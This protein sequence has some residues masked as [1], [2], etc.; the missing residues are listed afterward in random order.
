MGH[1][2]SLPPGHYHYI[3]P[4]GG[5][6]ASKFGTWL[7]LATEVHL[8]TALFAA[9]AVM[10]WKFPEMFHEGAHHLNWKLGML[11]TI[12]LLSSSYFMVRGV[13]A[14]QHGDNKKTR[15]WLDLTQLCAV[16]F[17]V[18]KAFEYGSKFSHGI[19]PGTNQFYGLYFTM[20]GIHGVHVIVGMGLIYWLRC[21]T[22]SDRFSKNFY[23]PVETVGLYWHLVDA[24]WIFLYPIV[25]LLGGVS[26][27][28][29]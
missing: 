22:K 23:T 2:K 6:H 26:L 11:N 8:F 5:Y 21:L 20:T 12:V 16:I 28:I 10:R 9:F 1:G 25:Y 15:F 14:A 24:V 7:F 18:V 17:L 27:G 3:E 19:T 13:D 29:N 4:E